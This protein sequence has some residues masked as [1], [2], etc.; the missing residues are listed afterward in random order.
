MLRIKW[1]TL[2]NDQN[3]A[4]RRCY[5]QENGGNVYFPNYLLQMN[6]EE[7]ADVF[8]R[9]EVTSL[10]PSRLLSYKQVIPGRKQQAVQQCKHHMRRA[11]FLLKE[12]NSGLPGWLSQLGAQ[13]LVVAQVSES[14]NQALAVD[15]VLSEVSASLPPSPSPSVPPHEH[16]LK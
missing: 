5:F 6:P 12:E 16:S 2:K 11:K 14:W 4:S 7:D 15:S 3:C 10:W 8:Q 13:L 1:N 9:W